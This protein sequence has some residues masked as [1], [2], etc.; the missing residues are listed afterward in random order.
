VDPGGTRW[1][2]GHSTSSVVS[3]PGPLSRSRPSTPPQVLLLENTR[4]HKGEEAGDAE[5]AKQLAVGYDIYVN[6]AFGAVHR[7]HA[8]V[9]HVANNMPV[10]VPGFVMEKELQFLQV[11]IR[12]ERR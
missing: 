2:P 8:S 12:T 5:F 4:F 1:H 3:P 6:D 7:A 9:D 10:C 11:P